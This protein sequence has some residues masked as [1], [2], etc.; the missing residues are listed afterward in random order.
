[1]YIVLYILYIFH[2][3][4]KSL[5]KICN[6]GKTC[7]FCAKDSYHLPRWGSLMTEKNFQ[8]FNSTDTL[9]LSWVRRK[10][11]ENFNIKIESGIFCLKCSLHWVN[12]ANEHFYT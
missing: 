2:K 1:M 9:F 6:F 12:T 5:I 7:N 8:S 10:M 11:G 4:N 3:L